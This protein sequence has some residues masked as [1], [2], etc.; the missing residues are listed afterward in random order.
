M[1]L[2]SD[3]VGQTMNLACN[4]VWAVGWQLFAEKCNLNVV[5]LSGGMIQY[6]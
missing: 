3:R 5:L 4:A 6:T 2:V 1:A